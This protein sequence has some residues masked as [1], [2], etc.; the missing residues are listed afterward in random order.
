MMTRL[1]AHAM[2]QPVAQPLGSSLGF[3]L[4]SIYIVIAWSI[5][6][7]WLGEQTIYLLFLML[8]WSEGYLIYYNQNLQKVTKGLVAA[9]EPKFRF[10]RIL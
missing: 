7:V 9:P 3:T 6:T 8:G 2:L 1:F 10:R 4:F 5:A